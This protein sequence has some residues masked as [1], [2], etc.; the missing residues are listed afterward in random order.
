LSA[1]A[2]RPDRSRLPQKGVP[3]CELRG[4]SGKPSPP[5]KQRE[6]F[7]VDLH[8]IHMGFGSFSSL[9]MQLQAMVRLVEDGKIGAVGVSNF[10]ARQMEQAHAT[11]QDHGLTLAA[12]QVRV[13]FLHRKIESDGVLDT[14]WRL[15]ITLI[16][17]SP[18]AGGMLTG[19][20]HDDRSLV[21]KMP[22]TRRLYGFT[23]KRLNRTTPLIEG[24]RQIAVAH[25]AT[26]S[27]VALAWLITNYGETV[28]AI[29]GAS[30]AHH[31]LEAAAAMQVKLTTHEIQRLNA[32]SDAVAN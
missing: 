9:R 5:V 19:K 13:N 25:G 3:C 32:L 30:K 18:L 8:Q 14:A 11:L 16:A 22:P 6:P 24:L 21:T 1:V 12:N 23:D 27:Q 2:S 29:P 10:S 20:F 4:V 17:Y 7:P 28:V 31:A 26:I 15:G